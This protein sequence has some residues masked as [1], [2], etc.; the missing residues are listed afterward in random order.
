MRLDALGREN[1]WKMRVGAVAAALS[2]GTERHRTEH[3]QLRLDDPEP[4]ANGGAE[5]GAYEAIDEDNEVAQQ[6]RHFKTPRNEHFFKA[7]ARHLSAMSGDSCLPMYFEYAITC[8]ERGRVVANLLRKHIAVRGK[9]YLDIGC[10]YGGFLVAFAEE[11]AN[12]T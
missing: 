7:L 2:R 9:R 6:F 1:S 12:V 11:G 4:P 5:I 8:N 3:P 10:A